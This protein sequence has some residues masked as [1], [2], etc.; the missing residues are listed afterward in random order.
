MD[1][2]SVL[3]PAWAKCYY[4]LTR[5][6]YE[7]I[8][9]VYV[10]CP[11]QM[12]DALLMRPCWLQVKVFSLTASVQISVGFNMHFSPYDLVRMRRCDQWDRSFFVQKGKRT[13][14]IYFV[15]ILRSAFSTWASKWLKMRILNA[16]KSL[17][18]KVCPL[19][20]IIPSP[21]ILRSWLSGKTELIK[22]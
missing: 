13:S 19:Q 9:Q 21:A 10:K 3:I 12:V 20:S 5:F 15:E 22:T 6:V 16:Q 2:F 17:H 8:S 7:M 1:Y 18:Y 4:D 14:R 11:K